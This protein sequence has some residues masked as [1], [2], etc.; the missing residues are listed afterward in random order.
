MD[1][2]KIKES[3]GGQAPNPAALEWALVPDLS[4]QVALVTGGSRGIGREISLAL[5][6]VGAQ[7]VIAARG[8][9]DMAL[10]VREIEAEGGRAVAM[11]ADLSRKEDVI[12]L[13]AR[14]RE[15]FGRLDVLINDAGIAPI[16]PLADVP[17]EEFDAL[18]ALN[19][20]GAFLCCQQGFRMMMMRHSGYII[21]ISSISGIKGYLNQGAYGA[22]K[23]GL[24]GLTKVLAMEA[25]EH[26]IRV[27][28][29]LPGAVDS[30]MAA[31]GRP[32]LIGNPTLLQPTD[33]ARAVL[34]LLSLPERA[35][36][37]QIHLRR[38][39]STPFPA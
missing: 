27:S 23:H 4:G 36:I 13:F 1:G 15:R 8:E 29:I 32:D 18:V 16:G 20:R 33:V 28:A 25:Q 11:A 30:P 14:L 5:G 10:V 24:M 34:F 19:L 9:A 3:F 22:T 38:Y 31:K 37:D 12:A 21:N 6:A 7:V 17:T 35:V 2:S 39:G 26:G